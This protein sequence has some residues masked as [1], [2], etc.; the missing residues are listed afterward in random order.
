MNETHLDDDTLEV[1][2]QE[3]ESL[4][5]T[6]SRDHNWMLDAHGSARLDPEVVGYDTADRYDTL[7][8]LIADFL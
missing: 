6:Y 3:Y 1:L 4:R 8:E 7:R 2:H 5:N